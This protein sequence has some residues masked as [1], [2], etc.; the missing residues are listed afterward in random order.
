M[1]RPGGPPGRPS[2]P[3]VTISP[4]PCGSL[5][6]RLFI[7][8]GHARDAAAAAPGSLAAI[9]P[10]RL[11]LRRKLALLAV[12]LLFASAPPLAAQPALVRLTGVVVGP[13]VRV[14]IFASP[15]GSWVVAGEGDRVGGFTVL[16]IIPGGAEIAGR[17]DKRLLTPEPAAGATSAAALASVPPD[18][19][20]VIAGFGG[21]GHAAAIG[22]G[23]SDQRNGGAAGRRH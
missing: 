8:S 23:M 11:P 22:P 4:R 18:R 19:P 16:R 9:R 15:D 5:Q 7:D 21:F 2:N 6:P 12:A 20:V 13:D 1:R 3:G 17:D 14:A 10:F